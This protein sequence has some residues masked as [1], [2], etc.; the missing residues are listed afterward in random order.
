MAQ[1]YEVAA[2]LPHQYYPAIGEFIFYYSQL[3]YLLHELIWRCLDVDNKQG[4][5]LTIGTDV[6]VLLATLN[7]ILYTERWVES[8]RLKGEIGNVTAPASKYRGL[9]NQIAHGLWQHPRN[10]D[11]NHIRM[12]YMKETSDQR[13]IPHGRPLEPE[14]LHRAAAKL[15]TAVLRGKKLIAEIERDRPPQA[16]RPAV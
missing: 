3:E 9:R 1:I 15:K 4:R 8:P 16:P 13:L 2:N 5:T 11:K 6:S 14:E 7:T 12:T 10:G